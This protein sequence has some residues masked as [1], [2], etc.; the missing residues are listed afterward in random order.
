MLIK[1]KATDR[2]TDRQTYR[3]TELPR[4]AICHERIINNYE[5]TKKFQSSRCQADC[6]FIDVSTYVR[7]NDRVCLSMCVITTGCV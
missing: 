6:C 5:I 7:Y 3:Q 1:Y 4:N 2:Q